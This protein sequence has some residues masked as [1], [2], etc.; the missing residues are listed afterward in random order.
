MECPFTT[1]PLQSSSVIMKSAMDIAQQS[2]SGPDIAPTPAD[3]GSQMTKILLNYRSSTTV[4][5]GP[6]SD[7]TIGPGLITGVATTVALVVTIL[8]LTLI[9]VG[10]IAMRRQNQC[11][12]KVPTISNEAYG[13]VSKNLAA[14]TQAAEEENIYDYVHP[15]TNQQGMNSINTTQ[16]EAYGTIVL[17]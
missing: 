17:K 3:F 14:H 7:T 12:T 16:N 9:V 2:K 15:V 10:V 4:N 1:S 6:Q 11:K 5:Q 13:T 8:I